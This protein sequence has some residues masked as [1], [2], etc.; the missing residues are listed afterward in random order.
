MREF[1][2]KSFCFTPHF[3]PLLQAYETAEEKLCVEADNL[4]LPTNYQF[5]F[6]AAT[7]DL[8][9]N[10]DIVKMTVRNLKDDGQYE[11]EHLPE[12]SL[13]R[14]VTKMNYESGKALEFVYLLFFFKKIAFFFYLLQRHCA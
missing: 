8:G 14:A 7:G 4:D 9:D 6:T 12:D 13:M 11:D 2:A 3:L 5:G 10:H 1:A